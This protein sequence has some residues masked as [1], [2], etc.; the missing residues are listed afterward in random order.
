M[1]RLVVLLLLAAIPA[2][3]AT[4]LVPDDRS[5]VDASTAIVVATAGAS[6]TRFAPGGWIETVTSMTIDE[7]IKGATANATIDVVE[8]G[9]VL[10]DRGYYVSGAPRY[11]AGERVLL[12]LETNDRGEWVAKN[13]A[14]GKFAFRRDD[15]GRRVLLRDDVDG[16]GYDG[17]PYREPLRAE[18][19]F[20]EF[21]RAAARGEAAA[22]DYFLPVTKSNLTTNA[23]AAPASTY[24][25]QPSPGRGLRWPSFPSP[26][27]FVSHGTQPGAVSGGLT[28]LQRGLAAW[29]ND[30]NSN[31]VLSYGGSTSTAHGAADGVT[32]VQFNDP[33]N[34]I[35]GSY[36]GV[37]GDTLAVTSAWYDPSITHTYNGETFYTIVEAD[38]VVQDGL[39][40]AGVSGNGF[41]H[42]ITHE[43]GHAI[44]LRHSDQPPS[45]GTSTSAAIMNSSVAFNTDTYGSNLQSWDREALAAVYGSGAGAGQPPT[46]NPGPTPQ[47]PPAC[48]PVTITAQPVSAPL[49][50][51]E[52]TMTVGVS[53]DLPVA[54]QWYIGAK[55]NTAN[56]IGGETH[57]ALSVSPK[58]TT[59]YWAR[60]TN[61]C[62]VADSDAATVTVNGCPGVAIT[63]LTSSASAVLEG[64]SVT[65][66]VAAAG[67]NVGYQW[68]NGTSAL[69]G[70]TGTTLVVRPAATTSYWVRVTNTC[71]ATLD[72]DV[73]VIA[74]TP[75]DAPEILV[76]PVGG[77]VLSG[78][79]G[80]LAAIE[81]G[82]PTLRYQWYEGPRSD[83]SRPLSNA[84][85]AS[86]TTLTLLSGATSYWLR[87]TNDCGSVDSDAVTMTVVNSCTPPA[88]VAQPSAVSVSSGTSARL[89]IAATGASLS[90]QWYQG[91]LLDFTKPVG[92]SSPTLLTAPISAPTQ[93]WVRVSSACGTVSSAVINV[94]PAAR[95][96]AAKP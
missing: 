24:L 6:Y 75:C 5:L 41:D 88:I 52:V 79:T 3:A 87:I 13:M 25:Q 91:P 49:A 30:G 90:Y 86:M 67:G 14:V 96:R 26:V 68:F 77:N 93:F 82:S 71:G 62:G 83:T 66:T 15:A 19:P 69:A 4:F 81:S 43:L 61:S 72:S 18:E 32:T 1:K 47:P 85:L 59:T 65:L 57:P 54:Y 51:S 48:N 9:G 50:G 36:R 80:V 94:A 58:V 95:R 40:G 38:L 84:S 16:F 22:A 34:E 42:V 55:G 39:S 8:L 2:G 45:G 89:T 21:V 78:T 29:T 74:V 10:G 28:A 37:G 33:S 7:A 44:G 17:A 20:L 31:V 27:V 53:G 92:R 70:Q 12:F 76:Q 35:A 23:T 63:S 11:D 73:V 56:P 60:V 46:P 64:A